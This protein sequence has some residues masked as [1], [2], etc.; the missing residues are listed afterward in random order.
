MASKCTKKILDGFSGVEF[1]FSN[2]SVLTALLA[3]FS[4]EIVARLACH[5]LAQKIGDASAGIKDLDKV[6]EVSSE[7]AQRLEK[8]EW[9]TTREAGSGAAR[10]SQLSEALLLAMPEQTPESVAEL[11]GSM[12]AAQKT[13][14]RKHP[15]V[16]PFIAQ[17]KIAEEQKRLERLTAESEKGQSLSDL[18]AAGLGNVEGEAEGEAEV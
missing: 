7:V 5:G 17:I 12:D 1:S 14:L 9:G 16:A 18:L 4:Q 8:G 2:G 3:S 15:A 13:A 11:L 10:T 6:V